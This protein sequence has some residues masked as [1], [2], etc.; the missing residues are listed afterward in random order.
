MVSNRDSA[1]VRHVH[2]YQ[3]NS[4]MSQSSIGV[5]EIVLFGILWFFLGILPAIGIMF[6]LFVCSIFVK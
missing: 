5:A 6:A 1:I 3:G 4:D 2:T